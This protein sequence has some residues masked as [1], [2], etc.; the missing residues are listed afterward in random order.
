MNYWLSTQAYVLYLNTDRHDFRVERIWDTNLLVGPDGILHRV[1]KGVLVVYYI[2][3]GTG[4]HV[5]HRESKRLS[6]SENVSQDYTIDD[7]MSSRQ[8]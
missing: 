3:R 4:N 2:D 7:E 5:N 6:H 1:V 8:S